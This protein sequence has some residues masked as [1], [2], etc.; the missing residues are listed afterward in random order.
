[1][2]DYDDFDAQL[3][4]LI[5]SGLSGFNQ[6]AARMETL[7]TAFCKDPK[8][9]PTFRVVDRRLQALRRAGKITYLR[10]GWTL[11]EKPR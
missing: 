5:G 4:N 3:L 10:T 6:L 7:A 9:S 1:M 11:S 2:Q 8:K